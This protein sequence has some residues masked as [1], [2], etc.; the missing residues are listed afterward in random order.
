V[1]I[2][3]RVE[4]HLAR[5]HFG[6]AASLIECLYPAVQEHPQYLAVS[7]GTQGGEAIVRAFNEQMQRLRRS[8]E[9]KG[10]MGR[11]GW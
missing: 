3:S 6:E 11:W 7:R 5:K 9:F 8:G 4:E 10:V 2:D 1:I